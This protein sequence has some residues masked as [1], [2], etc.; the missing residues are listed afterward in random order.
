MNIKKFIQQF[1]GTLPSKQENTENHLLHPPNLNNSDN[2]DKPKLTFL[3]RA[4][5]FLYGDKPWICVNNT[6][7]YWTGT[8]YQQSSESDER[9]KI[10]DFCNSYTVERKKDGVTFPY[11]K[12]AC[13]NEV[14]RWAKYCCEVNS[15]LINPPGLNCTNGV[16]QIEWKGSIPQ[17]KLINHTPNLYYIYKPIVTYNPNADHT[18]CDRLLKALDKPEQEIFLRTIA[19]SL[20][21]ATVRQHKG[22]L[23][24]A[25]LLKG[26]GSNGKDTLRE[27]VAAM[28]GYQGVTGLT[29]S[30]FY[31]Y[32]HGTKSALAELINSRVNWASENFN[33]T[34]I[35]KLQSLKA[36]ITG[37]NL[38]SKRGRDGIDYKPSAICLFNINDT[39]NLKAISESIT[40]R[41]AILD[42]SKIFKAAADS[43]KGELQ[44]DPRF[45]NDTEFI[46]NEVL[47][48]FLNRVL[49]ALGDLMRDGIDYSCTQKTLENIQKD[50][51]HLLQFC[52]DVGLAYEPN[53]TVTAH[54]I[55]DLLEQWYQDND[56]LIYEIDKNGQR[57]AIWSQ[58]PTNSDKNVKAPNQVIARFKRL[59]PKVEEINISKPGGG[60]SWKGLKGIGFKQS[61]L[62]QASPDITPSDTP[63]TPNTSPED[64]L[65]GN[66]FHPIHPNP[67]ITEEEGKKW[68]SSLN[69][70]PEQQESK[71]PDTSIIPLSS[72]EKS[73]KIASSEIYSTK[74]LLPSKVEDS[75]LDEI[76]KKA[77]A[78]KPERQIIIRKFDS[79]SPR[80]CLFFEES[81]EL[82][83]NVILP[84]SPEIKIGSRVQVLRPFLKS[85]CGI[86]DNIYYD[87]FGIRKAWVS[88]DYENPLNK[89]YECCIDESVLMQVK[90]SNLDDV[91]LLLL[92]DVVLFQYIFSGNIPQK[93][94]KYFLGIYKIF[95]VALLM[96]CR[97]FLSLKMIN[98]KKKNTD[99]IDFDEITIPKV[100]LQFADKMQKMNNT[101]IE[102]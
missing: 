9:R 13:V 5:N 38:T 102:Y 78:V 29:L 43:S 11:A 4:L 74:L 24:R 27:I 36:F 91:G 70:L 1:G 50:N 54:E 41:W 79:S 83:I 61:T 99:L 73:K 68:G 80:L 18:N 49:Q 55:W 47:P 53:G 2:S 94:I 42:F 90:F 28:Y 6:L 32:D 25:L 45:Q 31:K 10:T 77:E 19:A 96:N 23:V 58:Q 3:Q 101:D 72:E 34:S 57:K 95:L 98:I 84:L 64:S 37:N 69:Y 81:E 62:P 14:L 75:D 93:D 8:H 39:P 82:L 59:F 35:D 12:P 86:V 7:Y 85:I 66:G 63:I 22:R 52:E 51:S 33:E 67:L 26:D 46:Q 15:E 17:W 89:E 88:I 16:L 76:D 30:D 71:E 40:S 48:A 65:Q 100:M 44:A 87:K 56:I 97:Y 21:L 20:D 92:D 60:K